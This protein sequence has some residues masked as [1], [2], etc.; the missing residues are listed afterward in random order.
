MAKDDFEDFLSRITFAESRGKRTDSSGK[1]LEGPMTKYGTAKGELQVLD[2]TNK[3]PGYGVVSAKDDTPDERARV[4]R[5]YLN[6]R[7]QIELLT[8]RILFCGLYLAPTTSRA[9]KIG[10]LCL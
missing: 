4:G 8:T 5:D 3:K 9:P 6:G 7:K 2:S 10:P 1:L